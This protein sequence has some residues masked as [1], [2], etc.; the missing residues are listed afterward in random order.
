MKLRV[1]NLQ[2][3][4]W[5]LL[6]LASLLTV[7]LGTPIGVLANSAGETELVST[8]GMYKGYSQKRYDEWVK[9]SQYVTM[10]DETK[11]AVDIFRP[12]I[13][14]VPV[15]E[16]LPVLWTHARYHRSFEGRTMLEAD[17]WLKELLF[18]GYVIAVADARGSGASFGSRYGEFME[19]EA[20]DAYTITEW[21]ASQPW[22]SG[23]VGMY[24]KS[25]L[26]ISQ[27]FAASE[28][29]PSLKAI[30]PQMTMFDSYGFLYDGGVFK[31]PFLELWG[32]RVNHLDKMVPGAKVDEDRDGILRDQA[33]KEHQQNVDPYTLW[34][35]MP[36]RD[37]LDAE[38]KQAL[39]E[40]RS[41]SSR[42]KEIS[43]SQVPVYHLTGWY[44][45]WVKD[46]F[47]LYRNLDN[48]QK[49][50]IGPWSHGNKQGIVQEHL[51]WYDYHLKGIDNGIM[52]ED[53]IVYYTMS[54]SGKGGW[55]T[56]K[57][58][59]LPEQKPMRFYF[60]PELA[61]HPQFVHQG[62]LRI[63][64]P[65]SSGKDLYTVDYTTTSGPGSRWNNGA[66]GDFHYPDM[67]TNDQKGL[68]YTTPPLTADLEVTGHPVV[69]V[70]V[71]SPVED[72]DLFVYL[73]DVN[74]QGYSRYITEGSLRASSRNETK[75]LY[76]NLGLPFHRGN[77]SDKQPLPLN[78]PTEMKISLLPTS[79]I[80]EEGH[81]IRITITG[82]DA[83][84]ALTEVI[85]PSPT[86]T[87]WRSQD[88]PSYVELPVIPKRSARN[89]C[90]ILQGHPLIKL[91][92][93]SLSCTKPEAS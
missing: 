14:G 90:G 29:P 50:M 53:P 6:I 74:E 28:H 56:S 66:G 34:S 11:I 82:A 70:T 81:R 62:S 52:K 58:W 31:K 30:F 64:P 78:K 42:L 1:R 45:L 41:P 20:R 18:H 71:S 73:E 8:H 38:T 26:G 76:D 89:V 36:Y 43:S 48:P 80:F 24:G 3:C 40:T 13:G 25:Y 33:M 92:T 77:Q 37:S 57:E 10:P 2:K 54:S 16:K 85:T 5:T 72:L 93:L 39:Y 55:R 59:P 23:S 83:D 46:A 69:S 35:R 27:L 22:S 91:G 65:T 15:G 63:Q 88:H 4:F 87:M 49:I 79:Y 17:P 44:D 19:Q 32:N 51:R 75:L 68:T 60:G 61:K 21:L 67:T 12:S 84:N 86:I 7:P 47:L 9:S